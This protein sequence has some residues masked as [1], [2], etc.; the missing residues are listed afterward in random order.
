MAPRPQCRPSFA[1]IGLPPSPTPHGSSPVRQID[2]RC[3]RHGASWVMLFAGADTRRGFAAPGLH[4]PTCRGAAKW[5]SDW[6]S[7]SCCAG[8]EER[9]PAG[10]GFATPCAGARGPACWGAATGLGRA[11]KEAGRFPQGNCCPVK[12]SKGACGRQAVQLIQKQDTV[13]TVSGCG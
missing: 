12:R 8:R 9:L 2:A 3:R 4:L 5:R 6:A 1:T 11:C 10:G 7:S 13:I